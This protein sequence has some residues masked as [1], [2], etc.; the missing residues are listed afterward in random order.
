MN[1]Y[2]EKLESIAD[3][4]I[5]HD[6]AQALDSKAQAL[7]MEKVLPYVV[8]PAVL[9]LGYG[10]GMWTRRIIELHDKTHLVDASAKLLNH[11][12]SVHGDQVTTFNALFETFVPPDDLRFNTIVATHILEHVDDPVVVLE[13][14]KSWLA[15]GGKV[16]IIVPNAT[17]LHRKLAVIMGIQSTV[18]DF[19]PR[20]HVVGHQRVYDLPTL[21]ADAMKAGYNIEFERGLFLK[22]LPNSMMTDFSDEL[23]KA[24]VDISDE[25]P[26]EM[27]ANLALV[28]SPKN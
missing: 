26:A 2:I 6:P 4:H 16:V 14:A 5:N 25:M 21:R 20:D 22:T 8:G 15:P 19:S 10:D 13:R 1:S 28:I 7:D 12:R 9:E 11:A 24:L 17:S 27:M 18:Y 3:V 23:L